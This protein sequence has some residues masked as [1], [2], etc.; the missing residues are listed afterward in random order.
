MA[1][2]WFSGLPSVGVRGVN[3][4]VIGVIGVNVNIGVNKSIIIGVIGFII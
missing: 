2:F 4:G 3:T 1:W